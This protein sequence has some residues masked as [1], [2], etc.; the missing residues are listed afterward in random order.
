MTKQSL[1]LDLAECQNRISVNATTSTPQLTLSVMQE[2]VTD[3]K[4]LILKWLA[5]Y[6]LKCDLH[7][8]YSNPVFTSQTL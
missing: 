7:K 5:I 6:Q 1:L 4:A 3:D 8:A 2:L